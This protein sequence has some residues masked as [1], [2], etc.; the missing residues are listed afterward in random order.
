[1]RL[2]H[3]AKLLTV[4]LALLWG[5]AAM[6]KQTPLSA[7]V[8]QAHNKGMGFAPVALF[9]ETQG[10]KHSF[11]LAERL[12]QPNIGQIKAL[13]EAKSSTVSLKVKAA[14]GKEY[15]LE[16]M[17]SY[18]VAGNP[19]FGII[20]NS[21]REQVAYE[22]GLHYQGAV[23]G[24]EQSLATMSVFANGEVMILF[25]NEDGNFN[26]GKLEDG[27][28]NYILYT[29]RDMIEKMEYPCATSDIDQVNESTG[30]ANKTTAVQGCNKVRIYWEA[31][32]QL[33]QDKGT[34]AATQNYLTGLFNQKQAMY[35]N[36]E[37]VVE[38]SSMYVWTVADF[39]ADASSGA[40]LY[41]FQDYWNAMGLSFDGDY[42]Q[43]IAKDDG[44]L[45]GVS[46][47]DVICTRPFSFGYADIHGNYNTVPTYSWDV[48]VI[49]HETGHAL[50]SKHTHWCGWNTGSGGS[51]GSIDNCTTQESGSGCSSCS[52]TFLKSN[53]N[54]KGTV[55]SYC[56]L[57]SGKGIDLAN[58][59][60]PLPGNEIRN[61]IANASCLNSVI[62]ADLTSTPICNSDGTITLTYPNDNYGVAPYSYAWSNSAG[63]SQNLI[64]IL[65]PGTFTVIITDSNNCSA[66][67][68]TSISKLPAPGDGNGVQYNLPLCCK[69]TNYNFILTASLPTQ[70]TSCQTVGWLRTTSAVSNYTAA[71]AAFAVADTSDVMYSTNNTS[72]SNSVSATLSIAS[73]DPCDTF[74]SYFYTPFVMRKARAA[75]T[76]T[77]T[78]T[79]SGVIRGGNNTA[80]G[81]YVILADQTSQSPACNPMDTPSVR[82]LAVT[83]TGYTGRANNLTITVINDDDKMVHRKMD[84][85][86]NGTYN[87]TIDNDEYLLKPFAISAFD[88]NCANSNS[89]VSSS[90]NISVTR[91]VTYPA[92][93]DKYMDSSCVVGKSVLLSFAPDSCTSI[94]TAVSN[95]A[96]NNNVKLYPNP[97]SG[98][99]LLEFHSAAQGQGMIKVTDMVGRTVKATPIQHNAGL[100]R[101]IIDLKE[102]P[103]GTYLVYL[104]YEDG[105]LNTKPMKLVIE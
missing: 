32:Y 73:P 4:G 39:F 86:G 51:C 99:A 91:T 60:G 82:T 8:E 69:D 45:G 105:K 76:V 97:T 79:N 49:T 3:Y 52:A 50:G 1:M 29:D 40:A 14:S 47:L 68:S 37:L 22:E 24:S 43:L 71:Q 65:N 95:T 11:L 67:F 56:H 42:A 48:M 18:P 80:I 27:S 28:G 74:T 61:K 75:A 64:G 83:I 36:E 16:L 94:N 87:I 31:D 55:M 63:N 12:Y 90:V 89:C 93:T 72:I 54:W 5:N 59:F 23:K 88:Y 77:T 17:R 2:N 104:S 15:T 70:L 38:L 58:G 41:H 62:K 9:T 30:S 102:Q 19:N 78:G 66:S 96:Y 98:I 85:A 10:A 84:Y 7:K 13:F 33:Y 101:T 81:S 6:A 103:A 26:M 34:L 21:G 20:T 100:N 25:A 57:V 44:G 35:A 53:T 92:Q 46:F